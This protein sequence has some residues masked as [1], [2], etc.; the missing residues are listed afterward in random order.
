MVKTAHGE[1]RHPVHTHRVI[2]LT[3]TTLLS[4]A[5]LGLLAHLTNRSRSIGNVTNW[6]VLGLVTSTLTILTFLFLLLAPRLVHLITELTLTTI[7]FILWVVESALVIHVERA[8]FGGARCGLFSIF[9]VANICSE[10]RAIEALSI[11][12][13]ILLLFY[14]IHLFI[15]AIRSRS[16]VAGRS[17]WHQRMS[18]RGRYNDGPVAPTNGTTATTGVNNYPAT[19]QV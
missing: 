14:I 6:E 17:T 12:N 8:T 15:Y 9:R 19:T 10:L 11:I 1:S 5:T 7:L 18:E 2:T 16:R 13:W 3:L 4:I